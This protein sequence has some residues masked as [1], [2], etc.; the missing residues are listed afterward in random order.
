MGE[1][2]GIDWTDSTWNP[3]R[4]C[5]P[6]SEGCRN[7]YAERMAARFSGVG[8][9]YD[10]L[11]TMMPSGP[12]WTGRVRLIENHL[13][14]PLRWRKPRRIFVNSMSDLF[15][16]AVTPNMF[17]K[18]HQIM[19]AASQHTFQVLTKRPERMMGMMADLP[20]LP[21]LWLGVSVEDNDTAAKRIPYLLDTPAAVR[22]LSCEPLLGFTRIGQPMAGLDWI[23][24]GGESGPEARTMDAEWALAI[25]DECELYGVPF[26]FKQWGGP[27]A[28][29]QGKTLDG[30]LYCEFPDTE[31]RAAKR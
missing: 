23:I 6:V 11:A 13:S 19:R 10:G 28:K 14:D 26:F 5:S 20:E 15:H 29:S 8:Q 12:R 4:G 9:A 31:Q 25:R 3:L 24:V 18:I 21:N 30:R 1:K 2:T 22:F 16:E 17:L 7:C 27:K